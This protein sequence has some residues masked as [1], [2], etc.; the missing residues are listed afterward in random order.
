[1]NSTHQRA[2]QSFD[3]TAE[4]RP[5][6]I[7]KTMAIEKFLRMHPPTYDPR[8][9]LQKHSVLM[10]K[11]PTTPDE[12]RFYVKLLTTLHAP[13]SP[14]ERLATLEDIGMRLLRKIGLKMLVIDEAHQ[15]VAGSYREQRRAL[16]LLKGLTNELMIPVIAVGTEDA[17]HAIQTDTQVASRFD[18]LHLARWNESDAFRNFIVTFGKQLQLRKASPFGDRE[19]IRLLLASSAGITARATRLITRAAAEA[20]EDGTECIDCARIDAMNARKLSDAA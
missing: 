4:V 9:G 17:L 3:V 11:M 14:S 20:I 2:D 8:E 18:P 13:F 12:R 10:V 19:M 6:G 1:V 16:N 5:G 7:G 15:L